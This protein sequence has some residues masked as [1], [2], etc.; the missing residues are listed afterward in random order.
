MGQG[1]KVYRSS[2]GGVIPFNEI[3]FLETL[4]LGNTSS[5]SITFSTVL[6]T[7]KLYVLSGGYFNGAHGDNTKAGFFCGVVY[8]GKVLYIVG[9]DMGGLPYY[10]VNITDEG[11]LRVD[12]RSGKYWELYEV[13]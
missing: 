3:V 4:Y 6:D 9:T 1:I 12:G 11:K 7:K 5:S 10:S 2:A 8:G 13:R